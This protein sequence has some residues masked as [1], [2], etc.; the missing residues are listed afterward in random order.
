MK[1]EQDQVDAEQQPQVV[2]AAIRSP[3]FMPSSMFYP[4]WMGGYQHRPVVPAIDLGAVRTSG[5]LDDEMDV[6]EAM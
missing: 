3:P 6:L 4:S 1:Q 5:R 2:P